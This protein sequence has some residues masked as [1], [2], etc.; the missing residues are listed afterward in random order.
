MQR[1]NLLKAVAAAGV[2]AV[3]GDSSTGTVNRTAGALQN[4]SSTIATAGGATLFLRDWGSGKPVVFVAG[5]ALPSDMW[6]YQMVPLSTQGLRCIAY[7][8][9]GHG[10][11]S[12]PGRGYDYDTLADDLA[13]VMQSLDLQAVTLV[14][15][16]FGC[17]EVVRYLTR[18]GSSRVAR[19]LL[20]A[21]VATPCPQKSPDNPDGLD[22][23][24]FDDFRRNHLLRDFPK[25]MA[26][27]AGPFVVK[28]TSPQ[29][30]DWIMGMMQRCSLQAL[31]ECSVASSSTDFRSEL[32]KITL[33][34]LVIQGDK[35]INGI[36]RTGRKTAEM[37]PGAR[38]E[39]YE[40]APHGLFVTH[41]DRLNA[42]LLKFAQK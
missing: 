3:S 25:W 23:A 21:P 1:R 8:R 6:S 31:F 29:M 19:I 26:D 20:L 27:N 34:T 12:D 33:P 11:S 24:I 35:D 37:I 41:M 28:E 22:P 17:G 14:G 13:A 39:I 7:D 36:D 2:S 42:D 15:Y 40:G 10:R 9:R 32:T 16:S 38:F 18:H 30:V 4:E 5:W